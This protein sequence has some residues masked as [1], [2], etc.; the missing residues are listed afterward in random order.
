MQIRVRKD[1]KDDAVQ[2][3]RMKPSC[4]CRGGLERGC[5]AG[6]ADK[7]PDMFHRERP[8][9]GAKTPDSVDMREIT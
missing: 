3:D 5:D 4:K 6:L 9:T 7:T 2:K 8:S 1:S